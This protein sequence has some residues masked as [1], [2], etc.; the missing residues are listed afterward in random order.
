[1]SLS[2]SI[3][4]EMDALRAAYRRALPG[5]IAELGEVLDALYRAPEDAVHLLDAQFQ[6]HTLRGTAGSFGFPEISTTAGRIEDLLRE[7]RR[8]RVAAHGG[9]ARLRLAFEGLRQLLGAV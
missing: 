7:L 2:T 3:H 9:T 8:G 4:E 1:M 5:K 6:A